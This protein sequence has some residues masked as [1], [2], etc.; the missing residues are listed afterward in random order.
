MTL[1][2]KLKELL[3]DDLYDSKDWKSGG[4]V[5][6]VEWLLSMY[7]SK[8]EELDSY[9]NQINFNKAFYIE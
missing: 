9:I 6:R 3:P 8:K 1:E 2:E 7:E 5:E 4:I